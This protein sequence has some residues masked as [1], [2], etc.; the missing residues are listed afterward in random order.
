MLMNHKSLWGEG[1]C[2]YEL[3]TLLFNQFEIIALVAASLSAALVS[4]DG[5]SNWLEG[6][7]LFAVYII[8]ALAFFFL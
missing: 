6:A 7:Q 8:L 1:N 3:S 5:E 2:P 4:V